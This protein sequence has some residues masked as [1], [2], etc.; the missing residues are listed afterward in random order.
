MARERPR[1]IR[2]VPLEPGEG[3]ADTRLVG[4]I[5]SEF[6]Y[7]ARRLNEEMARAKRGHGQFSI[8]LF[9]SQ[10]PD[11]E[12]PEISCVRGLPAI[13]TGVRD[14]DCVARVGRET[15]AV[16]LI[17]S[18]ED[19]SRTAALRLLERIGEASS[20]WAI[21]ILEYP[22]QESVLLDLGLVA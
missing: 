15:I 3:G 18:R 13:L 1:G 12:L 17:D 2:G 21:R 7:F 9:T 5:L 19:A 8:V 11:G 22:E 14:T 20:R 16:L 4:Q 10:P 6:T